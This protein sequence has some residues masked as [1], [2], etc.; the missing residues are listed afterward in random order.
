MALTDAKIRVA[1]PREKVYKLFDSGGLYL[2]VEPSGSR[3]WRFK[4][5][6]DGK[7]KHM[8]FGVYPDVDLASARAKRDEARRS[9]ANDGD[10]VE[11]RRIKKRA[12]LDTFAAC[13]ERYLLTLTRHSSATLSKA[14]WLLSDYLNP[15]LGAMPIAK[16]SV[17]EI[18][19]ALRAIESTGKLETTHRAQNLASRIFRFALAEGV[20]G[21]LTNPAADVTMALKP[22]TNDHHAAITDPEEFGTLLRAI[23]GAPGCRSTCMALRILPHVF[24]RQGELRGGRWDEIDWD[25]AEWRIP[26]ERMKMRRPHVVPLSTQVLSMLKAQRIV[27]GSS[28]FL[29]P[30]PRAGDKPIN[31]NVLGWKLVSLGYP[32][33]RHV[34]HG[35]RVSASTLLH[36][37]G[38][39]SRDVE[40]QLA[41]MDGNRV[42]GIYNRSERLPERRRMMQAWSDYLDQLRDGGNV[43]ALH[44]RSSATASMKSSISD[45]R[46]R[47]A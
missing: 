19:Q 3:C 12:A 5:R 22:L 39:D 23:E 41:H 24:L 26:A 44:G 17:P 37:L 18:I 31:Q 7:E 9:V 46:Q 27:T 8:A 1:K 36:E 13:G 45:S 11:E 47:T 29:F 34:P 42:R 43:V 38:F 15:R 4:Y 28:A 6:V 25:K 35:F 40:L 2:R 21:L 16:I 32:S 30:T 10:P 20:P 14:K 33:E